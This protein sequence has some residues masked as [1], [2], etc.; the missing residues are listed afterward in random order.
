MDDY[1]PVTGEE[2]TLPLHR[3]VPRLKV[4]GNK[5]QPDIYSQLTDFASV[6]Y[7]TEGG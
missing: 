7:S 4:S 5:L 6:G 1:P 2:T 3:F